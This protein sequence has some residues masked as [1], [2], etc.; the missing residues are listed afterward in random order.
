MKGAMH[1]IRKLARQYGE[2]VVR[3][4]SGTNARVFGRGVAS[5]HVWSYMRQ[6]LDDH[7]ELP[8]GVHTLPPGIYYRGAN[9]GF[10]LRDA[11][12]VD[13]TKL[14]S[15]PDYPHISFAPRVR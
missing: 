1:Q 2:N 9:P 12:T 15:D 5:Y 14:R 8:S 4:S 7:D 3:G 6:W 13:F 11:R 10:T